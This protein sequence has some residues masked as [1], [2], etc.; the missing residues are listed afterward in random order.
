MRIQRTKVIT[1]TA[2]L[3]LFLNLSAQ[4][5][6]FRF[7]LHFDPNIS[8]MKAATKSYSSAGTKVGFVYGISTEFFLGENY[9]LSTGLNVASLGGKL[10]YPGLYNKN[11]TLLVPTN[12]RESFSLQYVEIPLAL[13]M[14]TNEIGALTY[15]G[16][17]G[18]KVGAKFQATADF[19]YKDIDGG[20]TVEK[21]NVANDIFF[22]NTW[23]V[24]GAGAEYNI[25]GS[26]NVMMG[27]S[28]NN[29][30]VNALT[31]KAHKLDTNGQASLD[32]DGNP[33][34]EKDK[35]KA[36]VSYFSLNIGIYF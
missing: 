25:S 2:F 13:K 17:F 29:G 33:V 8:W 21:E 34:L 6:K 36:T 18:F 9:L 22:I 10:D 32:V 15:F 14:R 31:N 30:F 3:L 7:G 16:T 27:L 5:K 1:L 24:V 23:L 12:I 35:A 28:F 19:K 11:D 20:I 4:D 26:T